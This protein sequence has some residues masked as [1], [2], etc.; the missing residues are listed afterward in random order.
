MTTAVTQ[1]YRHHCHNNMRAPQGVNLFVKNLPES[2]DDEKLREEFAVFGTITSSKVLDLAA[3]NTVA[4][5]QA[6]PFR[7]QCLVPTYFLIVILCLTVQAQSRSQ[8]ALC[9]FVCTPNFVC[10]LLL[11]RTLNTD[12]GHTCPRIRQGDAISN[13]AG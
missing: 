10:Q 12:H 11:L 5:S 3:V 6:I 7:T 1:P 4:H 9:T 13:T 8:C 2:W